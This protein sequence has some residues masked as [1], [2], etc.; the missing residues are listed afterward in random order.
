MT[1]TKLVVIII[2]IPEHFSLHFY[3]FSTILYRIY[4]FAVL[5]LEF[6]FRFY[7]QVPGKFYFPANIPLAGLWGNRGGGGG[8]IPTSLL[9]G[10]E[11][12]PGGKE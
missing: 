7:R 3:E 5:N 4:K 9:A 10:G 8:W 2:R 12:T 1:V 6:R 11:G